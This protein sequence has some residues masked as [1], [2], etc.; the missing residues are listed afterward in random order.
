MEERR[1]SRRG[2]RGGDKTLLSTQ[3]RG[4]MVKSEIPS[5]C[6]CVKKGRE[7]KKK[8]EKE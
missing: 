3:K 4:I 2:E 1:R 8:T 6:A 7:E 5:Q